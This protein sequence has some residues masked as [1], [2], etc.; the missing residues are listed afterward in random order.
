MSRE[1][2]HKDKKNEFE[3]KIMNIN[4]VIINSA[5]KTCSLKKEVRKNKNNQQVSEV[6][7]GQQEGDSKLEDTT[8]RT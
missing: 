3:C 7:K 5:S 8:S 4:Q 6:K 2:K 1:S